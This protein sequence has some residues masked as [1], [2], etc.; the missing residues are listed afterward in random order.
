M[1]RFCGH[2]YGSHCK[3]MCIQLVTLMIALYLQIAEEISYLD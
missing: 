3:V 2:F 1:K